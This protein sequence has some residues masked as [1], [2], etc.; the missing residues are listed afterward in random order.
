[1][2]QHNCNLIIY[3]YF[4]DVRPLLL[5]QGARVSSETISLVTSICC[6]SITD[7][8]SSGPRQPMKDNVTNIKEITKGN[9]MLTYV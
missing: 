6:S 1:M 2:L 3:K 4:Y 8:L 9:F 5:G 7:L